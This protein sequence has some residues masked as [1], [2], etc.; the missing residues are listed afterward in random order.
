MSFFDQ[1][2]PVFLAFIAGIFTCL[3]TTCGALGIFFVKKNN[4]KFTLIAESV[5][6]GIMLSASFFSLLLPSLE[7]SGRWGFLSVPTSFFVGGVFVLLS[8]IVLKKV[9]QKRQ[10]GV[11]LFTAITLHNIPEG[12]AVGVAFVGQ[13]SLVAFS[14]ALG[15]GIQNIPE[16][17]CVACPLYAE[18]VSKRKSFFLSALSGSIELPFAV[19]GALFS[20]F[21]A[22]VQ[23]VA[24]AFAAGA[25]ITVSVSE[26]IAESF[27]KDKKTAS[28]GFLLGFFVMM[29]LDIAL[30]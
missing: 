24:L 6:A 7:K 20:L 23:P 2:S 21:T 5:S 18:G 8:S 14:L 12:L 27:I 28:V 11:L 15:I 25:M 4:E 22:W 17:F 13:P 3:L 29:F 19:L 16:G 26:L 30:G 10:R 1:Y 9:E